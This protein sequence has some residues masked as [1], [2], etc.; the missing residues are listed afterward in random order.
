V[1]IPLV[2]GARVVVEFIEKANRAT[3]QYEKTAQAKAPLRV[4]TTTPSGESLGDFV[5][6]PGGN[7]T[8]ELR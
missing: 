6:S 4:Q 7:A 8:V 5:I 3:I 2:R 1:R